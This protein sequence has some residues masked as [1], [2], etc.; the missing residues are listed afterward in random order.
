ML[1]LLLL[2]CQNHSDPRAFADCTVT[3]RGAA[4]AEAFSLVQV[5]RYDAEGRVLTEEGESRSG[6]AAWSSSVEHVYEGDCLVATES[7]A[8]FAAGSAVNEYVH[9]C[10]EH[11]HVERTELT[12]REL[13]VD[14]EET[15]R[16]AVIHTENTHD[17]LGRLVETVVTLELSAGP[18]VLETYEWG[19]CDDP[20][21]TTTDR[22]DGMILESWQACGSDGRLLEGGLR[23]FDLEGEL[24]GES[25]WTRSYDLSGRLRNG[26]EDDDADGTLERVRLYSWD[27]ASTPGPTEQIIQTAEGTEEIRYRYTYDC[28]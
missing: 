3:I 1:A 25:H 7:I 8:T 20:V 4:P 28:P 23:G 18:P 12:M 22:G 19:L 15:R 27:E 11:G 14:G 13:P 10:D 9:T 6:G 16:T 26:T 5:T 2:A 24:L 17:L 21:V